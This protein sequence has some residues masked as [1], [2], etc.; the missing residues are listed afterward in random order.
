MSSKITK[1]YICNGCGAEYML[2]YDED[3]IMDEP[4]S[5]PFCGAINIDTE[6]LDVNGLGF[7]E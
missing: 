2:T 4:K 5:C 7:D 3:N 6:E 1:D